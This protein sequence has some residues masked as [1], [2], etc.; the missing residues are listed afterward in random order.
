MSDDND[1]ALWEPPVAGAEIDTLTGSLERQRRTLAWKCGGLD[2]TGL[3]TKLGPSS[4]TLGG[5][6]KHLALVEDEYFSRRLLG[7]KLGPPWD[8]VD[9]ETDPD[10]DWHSAAE[11][12]PEQIYTLWQDA[13]TRSRAALTRALATGGVDQLSQFSWPDGRTPSLRRILID[14]IEEYARHVGHADLIRESVDGLVGEDP[15]R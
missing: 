7:Q 10:W 13:V 5:L 11:D 8:A 2:A 3:N 1:P 6:L 12:P 9:W 4:M 15:P 14:M